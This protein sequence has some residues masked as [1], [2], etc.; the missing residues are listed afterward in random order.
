VV[1]LLQE[2]GY[3]A[4]TVE[5]VAARAHCSKATLYRR[6]SGKAELVTQALR[7]LSPLDV[8]V[9]DTGSLTGDL[10][11][12]VEGRGDGRPREDSALIRGMVNALHTCPTLASA[13]RKS[14]PGPLDTLIGRA[15]LRGE[16]PAQHPASDHLPH[17]L[18]GAVIAR[19]LIED[20]PA[21]CAFLH[22]FIDAVILPALGVTSPPQDEEAPERHWY[23][24]TNVAS[25]PGDESDTA[26]SVEALK[27]S[28]SGG[29]HHP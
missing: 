21:D 28:H 13:L 16:L 18:L 24:G 12:L 19:T 7:H 1:G 15:V 2:I 27:H 17:L 4:L 20:V 14:G 6:F 8:A 29:S 11:A 5:A 25:G 22:H 9:V 26:H 3:D 23:L 10:H